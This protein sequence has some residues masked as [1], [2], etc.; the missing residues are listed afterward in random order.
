[1]SAE[2]VKLSMLLSKPD[3]VQWVNFGHLGYTSFFSGG[4]AESKIL[5]EKYRPLWANYIITTTWALAGSIAMS[6]R[7]HESVLQ[8]Y[9]RTQ[10]KLHNALRIGDRLIA[11][12]LLPMEGAELPAGPYHGFG[13]TTKGKGGV[14]H[15]HNQGP[16]ICK[17]Q[18]LLYFIPYHAEEIM[19]LNPNDRSVF[20]IDTTKGQ[21][22]VKWSGICEHQSLLH[23]SPEI[24]KETPVPNP[25][26]R[27]VSFIVTTKDEGGAKWGGTCEHKG[28]L[29]FCSHNAEEILVLQH[30]A[31]DGGVCYKCHI[32]VSTADV[33]Q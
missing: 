23:F 33:A 16:G 13:N 17:H 21:G 22:G 20:F 11:C 32:P 29:Y 28:L 19:V 14:L 24:A 9:R 6:R 3:I 8:R 25:K 4:E 18:S 7:E 5:W 12:R 27:S 15:Q 26:D 31:S 10:D 1:M 2:E 30:T